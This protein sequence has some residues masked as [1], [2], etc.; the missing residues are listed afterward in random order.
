[1]VS[2]KLGV[3]IGCFSDVGH[4]VRVHCM[5]SYHGCKPLLVLVGWLGGK[6]PVK[7]RTNRLGVRTISFQTT[8]VL[9]PHLTEVRF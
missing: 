8:Y 3:I 6:R 9:I 1:M 7:A 4:Y 5:F 2:V